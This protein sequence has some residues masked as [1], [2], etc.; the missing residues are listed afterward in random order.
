MD[1]KYGIQIVSHNSNIKD[2]MFILESEMIGDAFI[3]QRL[4][5]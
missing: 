2:A 4:F 5:I 1:P 3:T